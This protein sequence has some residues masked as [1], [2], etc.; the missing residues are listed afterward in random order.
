[1]SAPTFE[2]NPIPLRYLLDSIQQRKLALPDFQ[3]DFVW[4]PAMVVD[5]LASLARNFPAGSLLFIRCGEDAFFEERAVEGAPT[6][7]GIRPEQLVLDGQQRL[8]SLFGALMGGQRHRFFLRV[9]GLMDGEDFE[10]C[11]DFMPSDA[12]EGLDSLHAQAEKMR[13]PLDQMFKD[14]GFQSWVAEVARTRVRTV[15]EHVEL[16]QR[17]DRVFADH[18]RKIED[19]SF[20]V[21][22]LRADTS[23]EAVCLIFSTINSTGVQLTVFDLLAAQWWAA[24]VRLRTRWKEARAQHSL[25]AEFL[26]SDGYAVLQALAL[27]SGKSC[28]RKPILELEEDAF[29]KY[30]EEV[31]AGFAGSLSMLVEECGVLRPKYL[32]F[33]P[34]L[35]PLA[36]VWH[37]VQSAK[38]PEQGVMRDKLKRWFWCASFGRRY[39]SSVNS[40]LS[41][42]YTELDAWLIGG[43]VPSVILRS[44]F[45]ATDLRHVTRPNAALYRAVLA[46]ILSGRPL[47]FHKRSPIATTQM[48]EGV[49]DH[50]VFPRRCVSVEGVDEET[51]NSILNR[52]LIDATT[53][54]RISNRNPSDYLAEVSAAGGAHSEE[55][56]KVLRS[57]LLPDAADG[58]LLRNDFVKFI[59]QRQEMVV[60]RICVVTG[61]NLGQHKKA[62]E[63]VAAVRAELETLGVDVDDST[64]LDCGYK[65]ID[66]GKNEDGASILWFGRYEDPRIRHS[67]QDWLWVSFCP[68]DETDPEWAK[69]M[70]E[71]EAPSDYEDGDDRT[72]PVRLSDPKA[73]AAA[74]QALISAL[75]EP[76]EA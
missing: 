24:G 14:G 62:D 1:M 53:N 15:D 54:R 11:I 13:F 76:V 3:R 55:L 23:P 46:L 7:D 9:D 66:I 43:P 25:I 21:V 16:R 35:V 49:D 39:E 33:S 47:D 60:E 75:D 31:I 8:T 67:P 22:T 72:A 4:E 10:D 65:G 52:A 34:S 45:N 30:W 57:H 38:G 42:D 28:T 6:L 17:L 41:A 74:F 73:I 32:P 18:V 26:G 59:G 64:D 48:V 61:W 36:A 51:V 27:R 44:D 29:T 19:Y 40:K 58:P 56:A 20:P 69:L 37:R 63:R 2:T 70:K 5:L 50:H 71:V 12:L 68:G